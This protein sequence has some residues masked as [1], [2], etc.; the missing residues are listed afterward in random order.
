VRFSYLYI[1]DKL[2]L[3]KAFLETT[4]TGDRLLPNEAVSTIRVCLRRMLGKHFVLMRKSKE[5]SSLFG[6]SFPE[7]SSPSLDGL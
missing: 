4:D 7:P 1:A 3:W 2:S 6:I 5:F